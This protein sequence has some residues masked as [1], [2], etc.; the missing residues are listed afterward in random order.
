MEIV[1]SR[2][3]LARYMAVALEAVEGASSATI[4]LDEFLRDAIEVDVD[5]VS[6]G[7]SVVIGGL[8]QHIEEAGVHSGDSSMVLPA[9]ALPPEVLATIRSSTRALAL[10]LGVVGLMNVQF[11]IRGS[12]VYV[13]EVNPR[14]SRTV[15]FVSKAIGVPLAKVA[16]QVMA[17]KTLEELGVA[18]EI[19][20]S[21]VAVKE[22]VFPFAKFQGVDTILGPEMRSTGEVMGIADTFPQAFL[23][24]QLATGQVLPDGGRVF[25][26]VRDD[27]KP[28]ASE[29]AHRLSQLGF[30]IL[31]TG[32]TQKVLERNGVP[33]ER[34]NKVYEGRPHVVDRLRDGEVA[35]VINTTAG[36]Q[37]IR[38]SYSLRRTT[39]LSGVPYFTTIAAASAAVA[40]IEARRESPLTVKSL[41]EYH[42]GLS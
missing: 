16:A 39:L 36:E 19:V 12:A 9:H 18:R 20:P 32:G 28:A 23:K 35:M 5:C 40:A 33:A 25:V 11:A 1:Y 10:E 34:V 38:D 13:I 3:D 42:R 2:T 22:S 17:G 6:D 31:A 27:D 26:S 7:E 21:H 14:A 15:P 30:E 8:M 41:Q 37:A 29:L 4:L 24:A